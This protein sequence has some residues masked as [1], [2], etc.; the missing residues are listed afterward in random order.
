MMSSFSS[1][2]LPGRG[3]SSTCPVGIMDLQSTTFPASILDD[4]GGPPL[5]SPINELL[6]SIIPGWI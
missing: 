3:K 5:P 2:G 4:L 6:L 1:L